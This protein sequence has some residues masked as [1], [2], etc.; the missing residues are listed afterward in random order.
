MQVD[1]ITSTLKAPGT[2][3]LKPAYDELLSSFA[4]KSN[5]RRYNLAGN[6]VGR[7]DLGCKEAATAAAAAVASA[8]RLRVHGV[9]T[10]EVRRSAAG[11]YTHPL[12]SST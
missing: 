6:R 9:T 12:L 5:L 8:A 3:R 7:F 4:F 1:P 11:A 10:K 2:K